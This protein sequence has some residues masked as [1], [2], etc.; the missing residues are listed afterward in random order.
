MLATRN[1]VDASGEVTSDDRGG[2][3]REHR[4]SDCVITDIIAHHM[5][6]CDI[7][8]DVAKVKRVEKVRRDLMRRRS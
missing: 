8:Y 6:N 2:E 7:S 4:Y 1:K 3:E 5:N